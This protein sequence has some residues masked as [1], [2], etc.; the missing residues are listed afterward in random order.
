MITNPIIQRELIGQL[1]SVKALVVQ[2]ILVA[3]LATLV[4][5]RWPVDAH[6]DT[7]GRQAQQ[8]LQLFGYGTM[9]ALLL[10][11]PAFP[12][13]TIVREKNKG[14]LALLLNSPL[15]RWSILSGKLIGSLG[16]AI[17]LL[18]LSLPAA[19]AC[20]AMGGVSPK[21]IFAIYAVL[22]LMALQY[23]CLGLLVSSFAQRPES[24][25][26]F[27]YG[28]IL[29]MAVLTLGPDQFL[30][31]RNFLSPAML[32]ASG[33]LRNLSP[34]PAIMEMLGQVE[35]LNKGIEST[36][37]DVR[38]F[39]LLAAVTSVLF[40]AW[41]G[42]RLSFRLFDKARAK[43][44][45]TDERSAGVQVFRRIMFLW[46]FDPQRRTKLIGPLT[47][48]VM[49]KEFRTRKF[50]RGHWTIRLF[51]LCLIISLGLTLATTTGTIQWGPPEIARIVVLMQ[52]ALIVLLTPSLT[53][54]FIAGER[55][56]GGWLL[57]QA[58]PLSAVRIVWGKLL[59]ALFSLSMVLI[60]TLPCYVVLIKIDEGRTATVIQSA[61]GLVITTIMALLVSASISS[62]FKSTA[63]ATATAYGVLLALCAGTLLFWLG[64]DAPFTKETVEAVLKFN[65]LAAT[66]SAVGARGFEDYVLLPFN[67]YFTLG[68]SAVALLVLIVQVWRLSKPQ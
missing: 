63:A 5:L 38:R 1:R 17:L 41:T 54:G 55:E 30:R 6:V 22:A 40:G 16:F 45:V 20:Y 31:G 52:F 44:K 57:L 13:V 43:G 66:L 25:L 34:L 10:M 61:I 35:L 60:A 28:F 48:P 29:A 51:F 65:P 47:N 27:T 68:L 67:W 62:L 53:G 46:F 32:D 42:W 12:A 11:I 37:S 14:T 56:S 33:W 59:S 3:L 39:V 36:G 58:T 26:R 15:G 21:Q 24:A 18:L 2:I 23:S 4:L 50:G 19:A 9:V 8:V 49:V 7:T 64:R